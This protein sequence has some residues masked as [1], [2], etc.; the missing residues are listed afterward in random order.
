[1]TS[2]AVLPW[3]LLFQDNGDGGKRSHHGPESD[4]CGLQVG[5]DV[6]NDSCQEPFLHP[7]VFNLCAEVVGQ[8]M[9]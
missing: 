8:T 2:L 9:E 6:R 1:M 5:E 7:Y 3:S 4:C